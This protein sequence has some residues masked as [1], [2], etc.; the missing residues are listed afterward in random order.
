MMGFFLHE[1]CEERHERL[2]ICMFKYVFLDQKKR[3]R[4]FNR[5]FFSTL[6]LS[7]AAVVYPNKCRQRKHYAR[8]DSCGFAH[9]EVLII[10]VP[11]VVRNNCICIYSGCQYGAGPSIVRISAVCLYSAGLRTTEGN[12]AL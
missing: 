8:N 2:L 12:T 6:P 9:Y 10:R 11:F 4:R 5:V 7:S 3:R 1:G